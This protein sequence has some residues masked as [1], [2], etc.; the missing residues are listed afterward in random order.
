MKKIFQAKNLCSGAFGG[1]IRPYTKTK[2]PARKPISGT[3][4]LLR[5]A[6]MPSPPPPQSNFRAALSTKHSNHGPPG[7]LPHRGHIRPGS[8]V[9]E[10]GSVIRQLSP[11][12]PS[13]IS[14]K[15][16]VSPQASQQSAQSQ[17]RSLGRMGRMPQGVARLNWPKGC[18]GHVW[19]SDTPP[20]HSTG[21]G[22]GWGPRHTFSS[23]AV[24]LAIPLC[25]T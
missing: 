20:F 6:P 16:V 25:F 23:C 3:P 17:G 8:S 10:Q 19:G 9:Y 1:N 24:K 5:W 13:I 14:T 15:L 18:P 2:G 12:G 22:W 4:P 21:T 7:Q 11:L